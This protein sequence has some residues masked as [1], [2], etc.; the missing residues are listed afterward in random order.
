MKKP[1]V[2]LRHLQ[3]DTIHESFHCHNNNDEWSKLSFC[4]HC[5]DCYSF[6]ILKRNSNKSITVIIITN[7]L[8]HV[9]IRCLIPDPCYQWIM[10]LSIKI[11]III[12]MLIENN[13]SYTIPARKALWCWGK[14]GRSYHTRTCART[15]IRK[16]TN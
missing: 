12:I 1:F 2:S 13:F 11:I 10:F 4:Y 14:Q 5:S 7:Q 6:G 9:L 15:Y 8:K 3:T 16:P